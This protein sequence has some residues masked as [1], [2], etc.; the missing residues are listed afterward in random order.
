MFVEPLLNLVSTGFAGIFFTVG[1]VTNY[2]LLS[3]EKFKLSLVKRQC[4]CYSRQSI[5]KHG[6]AKLHPCNARQY[7]DYCNLRIDWGEKSPMALTS[8]SYPL[9]AS[10]S[11][12]MPELVDWQLFSI[13]TCT[14]VT[15]CM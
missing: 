7:A 12:E 9:S 1:G 6:A 3:I 14:S 15:T 4:P 8:S 2:L 13:S 5:E 11:I 10:R